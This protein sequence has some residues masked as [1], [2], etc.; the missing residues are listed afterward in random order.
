MITSNW[1]DYINAA[2][3]LTTPKDEY[4]VHFILDILEGCKYR[5]PG[6][7]VKKRGNY[8]SSSL[9]NALNTIEQIPFTLNDVVVGPTDFFGADNILEILKDDRM[10]ALCSNRS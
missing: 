7:F 9:T 5:C 8:H 1:T 10:K 6:C 3:V 2:G 4:E